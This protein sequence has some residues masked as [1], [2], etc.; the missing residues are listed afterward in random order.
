LDVACSDFALQKQLAA[1]DSLHLD[2]YAQD[3][4]GY[5]H[6]RPL[7]RTDA[8]PLSALKILSV[9]DEALSRDGARKVKVEEEA[10]LNGT[11]IRDLL[12][13]AFQID[14]VPI[15][16][17]PPVEDASDTRDINA[18]SVVTLSD[19]PLP[20]ADSGL[21]PV[22]SPSLLRAD[23]IDATTTPSPHVDAVPG[24]GGILSRNQLINSWTRRYR[25]P[26]GREPVVVEGDPQVG[27]NGSQMMAIAMMLSER[28][29]L[30]QGV[31][32]LEYRQRIC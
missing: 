8:P 26:E 23:D 12:L 29:S 4:A 17:S 14:F 3:M 10:S 9:E 19:E 6:V 31:S 24:P 15:E 2:P 20:A 27:L 32:D 5:P 22:A 16:S 28:L 7:P 18:Q 21:Q 25:T 11:T 1:I 13:R 30:V